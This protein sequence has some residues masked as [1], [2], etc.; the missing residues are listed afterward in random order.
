MSS[1]KPAYTQ[2][3]QTRGR[4]GLIPLFYLST[5]VGT[6]I[7]SL[8]AHTLT[9]RSPMMSNGPFG[10]LI[11]SRNMAENDKDDRRNAPSLTSLSRSG[12]QKPHYVRPFLSFTQKDL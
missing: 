11:R 6:H 8:H 4:R 7:H 10:A 5:S 3:P 9:R 2:K 1:Q 12:L